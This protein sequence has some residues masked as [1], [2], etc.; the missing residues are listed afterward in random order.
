MRSGWTA[1]AARSVSRSAEPRRR[2]DRNSQRIAGFRSRW[3]IPC[4]CAASSASAICVAMGSAS[5][6]GI[7]PWAIRSASVGPSISSRT[8]AC[9][10]SASSIPWICLDCG[11]VTGPA[12]LRPGAVGPFPQSIEQVSSAAFRGASMLS[13]FR[14][15]AP[16]SRIASIRFS[17][18][19]C[20]NRDSP[21]GR[22][23]GAGNRT[24]RRNLGQGWRRG[25]RA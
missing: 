1:S 15:C 17:L 23:R 22:W 7:G 10:L 9:V 13:I 3:M 21:I 5:S 14:A 11:F 19:N 20:I 16:P 4:S 12:E 8:S 24:S 2:N 25:G 6:T 18:D